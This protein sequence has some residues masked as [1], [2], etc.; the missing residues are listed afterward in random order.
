MLPLIFQKGE[1]MGNTCPRCSVRLD[2]PRS[3]RA[4]AQAIVTY[5]LGAEGKEAFIT[6]RGSFRC[7]QCDLRL[8][9]YIKEVKVGAIGEPSAEE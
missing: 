1:I 2:V 5:S 6:K 4:T 9:K 8:N 7:T 3:I